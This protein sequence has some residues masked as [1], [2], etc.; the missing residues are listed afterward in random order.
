MITLKDLQIQNKKN[1][2][3]EQLIRLFPEEFKKNMAHSVTFQVTEQCNLRCTYCYQ[4]DKHN[5]YMPIEVGKQ[6]IDMLLASTP[7]NNT[8]INPEKSPGII[9]DFIGGEPLLAIDVITEL[10]EYFK[11]RTIE[12]QHPWANRH[13]FSICSNGL[14]YFDPKFQDLLTKYG[15]EIS[16]SISIDGIK[17]LHDMCRL[18][19][20]G[21]GSYDIA[22]AAVKDYVERSLGHMGSKMTL[23]PENIMWTSKAIKNLVE[24][25][26][27]DINLNCVFEK[28][29]TLKDANKLYYQLKDAADYLI[30]NRKYLDT[31]VSIFDMNIGKPM[32][33]EDNK[34]WCGGT[35]AMLA[36][37]YKGDIYPCL[38]YME[39]SVGPNVPKLIIGNVWDGI[40]IQQEEQ[41]RIK[42]LECI[43]RR[44]QSTD[45]CFNCPIA[46]GCAWCFPAGTKINT[47]T[48]LKNIEDLKIGDKVIDKDGNSQIVEN[49]LSRIASSDL[50]Y[51]KAAGLKDILTT[52]EHPFYAK[53]VIKK[54]HN[55][56]VYGEPKWIPAGELKTTDK[57][58]IFIPKSGNKDIDKNFAYVIGRYVGDGWKTPSNRIAH[59]Y[60][61]YICT[62]FD[63]QKDFEKKLDLSGIKYS[64]HENRT[65]EEYNLNISNNE[66]LVSLLEDCGRKANDKHVPEEVWN[67]NKE[68]IQA[69]LKGYFD[70]DGSM[71]ERKGQIT[72]RFTSISYELIL[73]IAELVRMVY[74]KNVNITERYPHSTAI[75]EERKVNQ[76]ISY[77]GRFIVGEPKRRYYEYDEKNNIMWINV[78]KSSKKCPK[79]E[80]VYNLTISNTHSFIANGAIVHNCSAYNYQEFGTAD[81]RATYICPMHK[82]RVLANVYYWNSIFRKEGMGERFKNWVP[83]EWALEIIDKDE[84]DM[85]NKLAEL[86]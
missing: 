18:Q 86:N 35:G 14:L 32:S 41:Q 45:E 31:E 12:L 59:P 52:K 17:E 76:S 7:E 55:L 66:Y 72:Q 15:N 11:K 3:S 49:N 34:N 71:S 82:A 23:A 9:I 50:I 28:G 6:G 75:I 37:D 80:I 30:E 25:G 1:E 5:T 57:I 56:P 77:E 73:N 38:R 70:A 58:G 61:Y 64:K 65:V 44:S 69:F 84:L 63:E 85:L 62:A 83:E 54:V 36:I 68:S 60:R 13:R 19:P 8:Y 46:A 39:S 27:N 24:L 16:F 4:I 48:G 42:C 10:I 74:H 67:W 51:L 47:P 78:S 53:K 33:K 43:T 2:Y 29:W 20:N 22:I 79:E 21:E 26:Y 40:G 81:H